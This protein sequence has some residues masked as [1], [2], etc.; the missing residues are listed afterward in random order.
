V[1]ALLD[2]I[3]NPTFLENYFTVARSDESMLVHHS[4]I[5]WKHCLIP[6]KTLHSIIIIVEPYDGIMLVHHS[7][8]R[9]KHCQILLKLFVSSLR[10]GA[11]LGSVEK[12]WIS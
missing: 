2:S 6:F 1:E 7:A 4:A 3:K 11:L 5:R 8:I 10:P 9:W 12:P